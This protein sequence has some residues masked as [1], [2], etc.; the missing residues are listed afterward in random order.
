MDEIGAT[1]LV[2]RCLV[3]E[4]ME[5]LAKKL[6]NT[7]TIFFSTWV[8]WE[9]SLALRFILQKS[10]QHIWHLRLRHRLQGWQVTSLGC[11]YLWVANNLWVSSGCHEEL[12]CRA[13]RWKLDHSRT[14][15]DGKAVGW[16]KLGLMGIFRWGKMVFLKLGLNH[17]V[18]WK[19]T[20]TK[21]FVSTCFILFLYL[22][23]LGHRHLKYG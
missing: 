7:F 5:E 6:L 1:R 14:W 2:I 16:E 9:S 22:F 18:G 11:G 10:P 17:L 8:Y 20:C 4:S 19:K 23:L 13:N 3:A 15:S 21:L 12:L